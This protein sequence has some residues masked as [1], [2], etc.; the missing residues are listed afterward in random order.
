[1]AQ[2]TSHVRGHQGSKTAH[3]LAGQPTHSGLHST[4]ATSELA[5]NTVPV[6]LS[7]GPMTWKYDVIH[8]TGST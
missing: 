8:K 3:E 6:H 4:V 2:A 5:H 1:M 7:I